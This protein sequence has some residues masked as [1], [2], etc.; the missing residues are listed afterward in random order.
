MKKR[1]KRIAGVI[2]G[3]VEE[4][5][6]RRAG[7]HPGPYKHRFGPGAMMVC[8]KKGAMIRVP[9]DSVLIVSRRGKRLWVRQ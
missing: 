4:I 8:L 1:S 7:R 5:R 6:Y 9:S 2:P 3:A